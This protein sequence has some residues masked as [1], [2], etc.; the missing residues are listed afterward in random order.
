MKKHEYSCR[1]SDILGCALIVS[2]FLFFFLSG[3]EGFFGMSTGAIA[4][5]ILIK[6]PIFLLPALFVIF[7]YKRLK[8]QLPHLAKPLGYNESAML[9]VSSFGAIVLMKTLYASVFP[10]VFEPSGIA[11]TSSVAGFILLFFG[12]V[13]IPSLM[14]E[15]LFRSIILRALT[16]YRVLLAI[17]ISSIA[18]ALMRFSL[19]AFPIY[20]FCGFMIG[21]V[22]YATGSFWAAV[23]LHCSVSAVGFLSESVNVYMP[24]KSELFSRIL[25][26]SCVLL[27]AFGL[28]FLKQTVRALLA[29]EHDGSDCCPVSQ[30]WGIPIV[31]F[32][33]ISVSVPI[34][35]R[36]M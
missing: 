14:E 19:E 27:F 16:S 30:F 24:E 29:D 31:I 15:I 9:T 32:L 11:Q 13:I 35:A 17:I 28:P 20:F 3:L 33:V 25:I 23:G 1:I 2:M 21:S 22:Y 5:K 6:I 26:A 18:Y 36:A 12:T 34:I 10:S 4:L 8:W 7:A